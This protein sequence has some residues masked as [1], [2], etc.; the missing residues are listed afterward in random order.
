MFCKRIWPPQLCDNHPLQQFLASQKNGVYSES[1]GTLWTIGSLVWKVV[2]D[3]HFNQIRIA[4]NI[5]LNIGFS[6]HWIIWRLQNISC[7][8]WFCIFMSNHWVE[9]KVPGEFLKSD[10]KSESFAISCGK[11]LRTYYEESCNW[12]GKRQQKSAVHQLLTNQTCFTDL[13]ALSSQSST[14]SQSWAN[15]KE[16]I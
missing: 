12:L 10:K 1:Y 2:R 16:Q 15:H 11:F 13:S 8:I 3:N 14:T 6:S 4:A 9:G 5:G 7:W